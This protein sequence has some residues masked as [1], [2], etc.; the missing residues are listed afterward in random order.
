M[1]QF[2]NIGLGLIAV[3]VA[4]FYAGW[5]T[6]RRQGGRRDFTFLMI[7]GT[8]LLVSAIPFLLYTPES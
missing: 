2:K 1:P 6:R 5:D 8:V 7:M 3:A 4:C